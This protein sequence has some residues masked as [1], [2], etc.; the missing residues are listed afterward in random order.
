[1]SKVL[2]VSACAILFF[3]FAAVVLSRKRK[4]RRN[5]IHFIPSAG[6]ADLTEDDEFSDI[7]TSTICEEDIE[8]SAFASVEEGSYL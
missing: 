5:G 4:S 8:T 2:P 6:N 1:L 7:E 3:L